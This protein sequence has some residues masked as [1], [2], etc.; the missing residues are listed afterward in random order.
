MNTEFV[1]VPKVLWDSE[2][3]S[4]NPYKAKMLELED[5]VYKIDQNINNCEVIKK[6]FVRIADLMGLKIEAR[7]K[8]EKSKRGFALQKESKRIPPKVPL[9]NPNSKRK[10][11]F[12][13]LTVFDVDNLM[14]EFLSSS[15]FQFFK[16]EELRNQKNNSRENEEK[17]RIIKSKPQK[18]NRGEKGGAG[19][20][21]KRRMFKKKIFVHKL[22]EYVK[23]KDIIFLLNKI[24]RLE[25]QFN[26]FKFISKQKEKNIDKLNLKYKIGEIAKK[27]S[28][29]PKKV[30]EEQTNKKKILRTRAKSTRKRNEQQSKT[31]VK[32]P[33]NA[34]IGSLHPTQNNLISNSELK[35]C[36]SFYS[37]LS[38]LA[39]ANE[40]GTLR[41]NVR[42][43]ICPSDHECLSLYISNNIHT[44]QQ[45]IINMS[46]QKKIRVKEKHQ[47][48]RT[49]NAFFHD[50]QII[51]HLTANFNQV[52][53]F[54]LSRVFKHFENGD[55][56]LPRMCFFYDQ[57]FPCGLRPNAERLGREL[58]N[59]FKWVG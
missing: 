6:L 10:S 4:F 33:T 25:K 45:R 43:E 59:R 16:L 19:L 15:N 57:R 31:E 50:Q 1:G 12:K 14:N 34:Q 8:V 29:C 24:R 22:I 58:V 23:N 27:S 48:S 46:Q 21:M 51:N 55:D 40:P 44:I 28:K 47:I 53:E 32:V 37:K 13:D 36:Q 18:S 35:T 7:K 26:L 49:A 3:N 54:T 2:S 9:E 39:F 17:K 38:T 41:L 42:I 30:T 11:S 5:N 52:E 56:A 20:E